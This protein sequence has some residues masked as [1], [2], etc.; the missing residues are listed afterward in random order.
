MKLIDMQIS[1][2]EF[3]IIYKNDFTEFSSET[4]PGPEIP[5][6]GPATKVG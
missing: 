6:I 3:M 5:D 2:Y 1:S 4:P